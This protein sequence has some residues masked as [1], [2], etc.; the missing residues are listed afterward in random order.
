MNGSKS[1]SMIHAIIQTFHK[2]RLHEEE[3]DKSNLR[4]RNGQKS[5]AWSRSRRRWWSSYF[6]ILCTCIFICRSIWPSGA[7]KWPSLYVFFEVTNL[8]LDLGT[9]CGWVV[10]VTPWPR[11]APGKG[12]RYPLY[13]RLGWPQSWSGHKGLRKNPFPLPGNE[14]RSPSH[15]VCS[16]TLYCLSYPGSY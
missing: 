15:P 1:F 6:I 9:I 8:I 10:S 13:R 7:V 4:S 5:N 16:Q 2:S 3:M 12:S 14:P 11:F